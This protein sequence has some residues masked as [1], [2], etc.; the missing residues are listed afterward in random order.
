MKRETKQ[1]EEALRIYNKAEDDLAA[2][3]ISH[4]EYQKQCA[5]ASALAFLGGDIA[6][7]RV[8]AFGAGMN[9]AQPIA[10]AETNYAEAL[11]RQRA[12]ICFKN[13]YHG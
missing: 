9:L 11:K 13:E 2:E 4:E 6:I 5:S 3:R 8:L 1:R 12:A 7:A 10:T